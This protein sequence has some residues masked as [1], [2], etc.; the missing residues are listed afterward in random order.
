MELTEHLAELQSYCKRLD[1]LYKDID[2]IL[3]PILEKAHK[4][5]WFDDTDYWEEHKDKNLDSIACLSRARNNVV[6]ALQ[7][8]NWSIKDIQEGE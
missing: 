7:E 1:K 4:E 5:G 3:D 8:L 2:V 6:D